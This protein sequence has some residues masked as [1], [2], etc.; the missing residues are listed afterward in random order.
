LKPGD[1]DRLAAHVDFFPTRAELS[2]AKLIDALR[3]QVEGRS[4][5]P[6]LRDPKAAWPDRL[7]VTH[8]GRW[9]KGARP[10]EYKYAHCSMRSP[11]WHL[12]SD[13]RDGKKQ[14]QLFDVKADPSEKTD[15]AARHPEVVQELDAAYDKWWV[16]VQPSL[17]S[18]GAVGPKVNPF[19][20]LYDK[21]FGCKPN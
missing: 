10:A 21:Q 18:E 15:V 19:K 2:G 14:W 12:V 9:P 5:A 20:E 8:V 13:A 3:A 4:L 11:R 1:V 16:S 6:L 7:L 17:V